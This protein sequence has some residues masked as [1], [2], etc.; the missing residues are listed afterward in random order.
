MKS[1][2]REAGRRLYK[3]VELVDEDDESSSPTTAAPAQALPGNFGLNVL[4]GAAS[5]LAEQLASPGMVL[6]WL[7]S[8]L[9][10]PVALTGL[11]V[12]VRQAGSLFPQILIAGKIRPYRRR[13]WFWVGAALV[14]AVCLLLMALFVLLAPD[15]AGVAIILLLGIFSVASGIASIAYKDVLGKTIPNGMRGRV[16]S[17]RSTIGAVLTFFAGLLLYLGIAGREQQAIYLYLLL[18]ASVL[19]LLS[20]L[21]FAYIR[22]GASSA[23][24][25]VPVR[26]EIR[27]GMVLLRRHA[28]FRGFLLARACFVSLSLSLPF[29]VLLARDFTSGE[30]SGLFV[31]LVVN[32]ISVALSSPLWGRFADKS[33]RWLLGVSGG[34]AV[35]TGVLALTI[36]ALAARGSSP[37]LFAPV[38]L[39]IG[40]AYT[41]ARI[42][43]KTY[44]VDAA[45]EDE[46]PRFAAISNTLIGVVTLFGG[47]LGVAGDLLGL[48]GA[49]GLLI[50]LAG[51]GVYFT[52]RMPEAE[53][54]TSVS[55]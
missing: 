28:G 26:E 6:P 51:A 36:D 8:A 14:Q 21:F 7:L 4:N 32:S 33:S 42:G 5:K 2:V 54:M 43:R 29:Y 13:K 35:L 20:V 15:V 22:E 9:G 12:P 46:R 25:P 41:G 39:L 11:L 40:F 48:R 27:A 37:Y 52:F 47:L 10:A 50:L 45:P 16:L 38:F 30:I 19:W 44:L 24:E 18:S 1:Q 3:L 23:A 55:P 53:A 17:L 34:L 31:F 49:I